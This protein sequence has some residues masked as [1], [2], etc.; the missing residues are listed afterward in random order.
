[1]ASSEAEGSVII[2][3]IIILSNFFS[4][5]AVEVDVAGASQKN[6]AGLDIFPCTRLDADGFEI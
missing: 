5:R 4:D 3:V 6:A 2:I 1:M